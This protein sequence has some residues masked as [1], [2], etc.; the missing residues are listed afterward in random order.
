M[1]FRFFLF[2]LLFTSFLIYACEDHIISDC[3]TVSPPAGLRATLQSIQEKVFT[4]SCAIA[5]C[6]TVVN[7]PEGLI[8]KSGQSW[9]NLVGKSS[10]QSTLNRVEAGESENSWLI[11]KLHAEGTSIM[12]PTGQLSPTTID[13]IAL[14]IDNGAEDN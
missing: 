11:K 10:N 13:T 1:R 4:P 9:S 7:P 14:W 6:H 8:L 5:G 2:I 12:P 3:E